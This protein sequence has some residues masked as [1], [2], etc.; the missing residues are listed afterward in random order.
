MIEIPRFLIRCVHPM[1][2]RNPL[3]LWISHFEPVII[4]IIKS[5]AHSQTTSLTLNWLI[6]RPPPSKLDIVFGFKEY[7]IAS[8]IKV[9]DWQMELLKV[10]MKLDIF[11]TCE[12]RF[13]LWTILGRCWPQDLE[14]YAKRIFTNTN[15]MNN[16]FPYFIFTGN[17]ILI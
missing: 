15:N 13:R 16:L 5:I 9:I 2:D 7:Y 1:K 10:W 14:I 17:S 12:I 8:F 4:A 6:I 3:S 11:V